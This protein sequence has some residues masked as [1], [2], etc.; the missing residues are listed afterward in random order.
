MPMRTMVNTVNGMKLYFAFFAN[1]L[2][3][4]RFNSLFCR[5]GRKGDAM[6]AMKND[7]FAPAY[8]I[9]IPF[10]WDGDI[11]PLLA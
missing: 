3:T 11:P 10:R 4:L 5:E 8:G 1:P 7:P 2:R 9:D 6:F